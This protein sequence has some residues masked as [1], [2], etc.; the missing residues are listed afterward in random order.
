MTPLVSKLNCVYAHTI[1]F[2]NTELHNYVYTVP[3]KYLFC[4]FSSTSYS[5]FVYRAWHTSS[6][7]GAGCPSRKYWMSADWRWERSGYNRSISF[8]FESGIWKRCGSPSV[9]QFFTSASRLHRLVAVREG[10]NGR[11]RDIQ[12]K[13]RNRVMSYY[14]WYMT[15][16]PYRPIKQYKYKHRLVSIFTC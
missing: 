12:Q 16:L 3:L 7:E 1:N 4:T 14:F 11:E 6:H 15:V 5:Y 9:P 13:H 2:H 8:T 10:S